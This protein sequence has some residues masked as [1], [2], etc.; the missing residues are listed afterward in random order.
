MMDVLE[1]KFVLKLKSFS[2]ENDYEQ[3][4]LILYI[5]LYNNKYF[6]FCLM[7]N[8]SIV[9]HKSQPIRQRYRST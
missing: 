5:T 4:V 8:I 1:R 7:C 3:N 9:P 2:S 6:F